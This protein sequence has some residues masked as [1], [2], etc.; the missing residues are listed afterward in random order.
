[1]STLHIDCSS[2]GVRGGRATRS[3]VLSPDTNKLKVPWASTGDPIRKSTQGSR[4]EDLLFFFMSTCV[5][6]ADLPVLRVESV[7]F[8]WHAFQALRA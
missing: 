3:R 1:M 2:Y 8:R 5:D 7:E 4:I 6:L